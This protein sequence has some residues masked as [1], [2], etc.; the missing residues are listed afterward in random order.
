VNALPVIP[1]FVSSTF[2]DFQFERD[3]L[4]GAVRERLDELVRPLGWR[5]E[6][7]DLRWGVETETVSEAE[8]QRRVLDVCLREID[9]CR[10][11]FV[12]LVGDRFGWVPP[13]D[14]SLRVRQEAGLPLGNYEGWS[15][16]ALEFGHGALLREEGSDTATFFMRQIVGQHPQGWADDDTA[17]TTWL[18][19]WVLEKSDRVTSYTARTDGV[20]LTDLGGFED[21]AVEALAKVVNLRIEEAGGSG[22]EAIES[23]QRLYVQDRL[24]VVVG[25]DAA[26]ESTVAKLAQSHNVVLYGPPG[27]GAST[28]LCAVVDRALSYGHRSAFH[29]VGSTARTSTHQEVI[30]HLAWQLG[31]AFPNFEENDDLFSWWEWLLGEVGSAV[32]AVDGLEDL[33]GGERLDLRF[34]SSSSPAGLVVATS[35]EEQR[36]A[37]SRVGFDVVEI[38]E[39]SGVLAAETARGWA[40]AVGRTIPSRVEEVVASQERTPLW[41]RLCISALLGLESDELADAGSA[42]E[43]GDLLVRA[44]ERFPE[45]DSGAADALLQR[46]CDRVGPSTDAIVGAIA[47][48]R[49]GLASDELVRVQGQ[50]QVDVARIRR[51]LGDFL[52]EGDRPSGVRFDHPILVAAGRNRVR[53][54]EAE[55]HRRLVKVL[56][57]ETDLKPD[58]ELIWHALRGGEAEPL[59]R[60]LHDLSYGTRDF[61]GLGQLIVDSIKL[62]RGSDEK[63]IEYLGALVGSEAK[64]FVGL[65]ETRRVISKLRST[66]LVKLPLASV[67]APAANIAAGQLTLSERRRLTQTI[68]K[69]AEDRPDRYL[70]DLAEH[71]RAGANE[72]AGNVASDAGELSEAAKHFDSAIEARQRVVAEEAGSG[73]VF[74]WLT[75]RT[76]EE[77]KRLMLHSLFLRARIAFGMADFETLE[78]CLETRE[79]LLSSLRPEVRSALPASQETLASGMKAVLSPGG[80]RW[81]LETDAVAAARERVARSSSSYEERKNL[82]A[83]LT[84]E[85]LRVWGSEEDQSLAIDLADEAVAL[86]RQTPGI[87]PGAQ[88]GLVV[89]SNALLIAAH[90]ISAGLRVESRSQLGAPA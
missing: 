81:D 76:S 61:N 46:L 52:V 12:G 54:R 87:A 8:A 67:L 18:R 16:T 65:Q 25:R 56:D 23:A 4:N 15:V 29:I 22:S 71:A 41:V 10:P 19:G 7:V 78:W 62:D 60:I 24:R 86:A 79:H 28:V 68:L 66:Q 43:I 2:R 11:L 35:S 57:S 36:D 50:S 20:N 45:S 3:L 80:G 77:S 32:V 31:Y 38:S 13:N 27:S 33:T 69:L 39:L 14:Q 5:V 49:S 47:L 70:P 9:R 51:A 21:L 63:T 55:L 72:A 85:G 83:V 42:K 37:L 75:R 58:D 73:S 64:E 89:L 82:S 53:G 34:L 88:G 90:R 26:I 30:A 40:A 74:R 48:S 6:M 44:V 1:I 84:V 17:W 59:D